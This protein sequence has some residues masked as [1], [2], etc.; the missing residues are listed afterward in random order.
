MT[1]RN[2]WN[3]SG[4]INIEHGG[5]FWREDGAEDYV[6][7]VRVTP[8]SDAGGPNNLYDIETGSIYLPPEPAKVASA[9]SCVGY[10][11][12]AN[13]DL[14]TGRE[15]LKKGSREY[16]WLIVEA[17]CAYAGIDRDIE[18]VVRIGPKEDVA[19][20]G[21]N[22]EPDT[23]LRSNAKLANYVRREFL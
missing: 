16:R 15:V 10:T 14:E 18:T 8:C 7:A 2:P 9:V 6:L 1:Q 22:P 17:F 13:G 23:I 20:Y 4:D 11:I 5:M 21:W 3:Y 12:N 19:F